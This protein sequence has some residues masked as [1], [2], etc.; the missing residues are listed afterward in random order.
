M[1]RSQMQQARQF[2]SEKRYDEARAI[3]RDINDPRARQMLAQIDRR[4]SRQRRSLGIRSLLTYLLTIILSAALTVAFLAALV[5]VTAS[6]RGDARIQ[7]V[8]NQQATA[9]AEAATATPTP[10]LRMGRVVSSQNINVRSGPATTSGAVAALVPGTE[11]VIIG[12]ND[13]GTWFNV[14]LENGTTGWI[15]ADLLDAEEAMPTEVANA[16]TEAA[17][18]ETPTPEPACNTEVAQGW[19]DANRL[20]INKIN[21]TLMQADRNASVDYQRMADLVREA[22]AVYEQAEYPPCI[23]AVRNDLLNGFIALL[24][25]WQNFARND[26]NAANQQLNRANQLISSANDVLLN[27]LNVDMGDSECQAEVWYAGLSGDMA[28]FLSLIDLVTSE[29]R[30]SNEIRSAIFDLQAIEAR[31][32]V[33]HPDCVTEASNHYRL[34]VQAAVRVFQGVMA[35]DQATIQS[36]LS[37]MVNE[38]TQFLN[39]MQRLGIRV[40]RNQS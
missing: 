40:E 29:T 19:Y 28:D 9:V 7:A 39:E 5:I 34:S 6:S 23:E 22:G 13:D 37:T 11:V 36:N 15:A 32:D 35:E 31:A 24:N 17:P 1:S 12:E 38:R 8:E 21:F 26:A 10:D 14:R 2:I 27:Q 18:A 3:L 25:G 20:E 33:A 4:T 16:P 30:P